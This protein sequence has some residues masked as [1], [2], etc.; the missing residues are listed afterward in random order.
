M[1]AGQMAQWLRVPAALPE[2]L[3]LVPSNRMVAHQQL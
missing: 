2:E 1:G 3:P